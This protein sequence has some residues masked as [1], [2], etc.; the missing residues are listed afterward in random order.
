MLDGSSLTCTDVDW[1]ARLAAPVQLSTEPAVRE[2]VARARDMVAA[3]VA[4]GETVYGVTTG[5]GA[6]ATLR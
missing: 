1:V 5:F 4:A 6:W 2:R 3:A